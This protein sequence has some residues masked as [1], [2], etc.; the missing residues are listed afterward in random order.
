MTEFLIAQ[1]RE[2]PPIYPDG[3]TGYYDALAKVERKLNARYVAEREAEHKHQLEPLPTAQSIYESNE[4]KQNA[5]RMEN[6]CLVRA[7]Q[8][9]SNWKERRKYLADCGYD[10]PGTNSAIAQRLNKKVD[11]LTLS[12]EWDKLVEVVEK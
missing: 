11:K 12:G 4:S 1:S 10:Y 2:G 5:E 8:T 6:L 9:L 3:T 7:Y